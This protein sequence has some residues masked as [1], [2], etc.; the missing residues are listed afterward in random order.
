MDN[1]STNW[2]RSSFE[3]I[4]LVVSRSRRKRSRSNRSLFFAKMAFHRN[5]SNVAHILK[6]LHFGR[7]WA[8]RFVVVNRDCPKQL[9]LLAEERPYPQGADP[10]GRHQIQRAAPVRVVEYV[11]HIKGRLL[12]NCRAERSASRT[13]TEGAYLLTKA[14]H[15]WSSSAVNL[16]S[17][18]FRKPDRALCII[19][20]RFCQL[21]NYGK[22]IGQW[23]PVKHQS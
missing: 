15:A 1:V 18:M 22:Y 16:L 19:A 20:A 8:A 11:V 2:R 4:L 5:A 17:V 9:T 12:L 7:I 3:A 10:K 6:E 21:S 23:G 13:D 14:R